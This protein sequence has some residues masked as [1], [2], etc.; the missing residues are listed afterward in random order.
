MG[1]SLAY[2]MFTFFTQEGNLGNYTTEELENFRRQWQDEIVAS[3]G[4]SIT[5]LTLILLFL[6]VLLFVGQGQHSQVPNRHQLDTGAKDANPNNDDKVLFTL[7]ANKKVISIKNFDLQAM[8][9]YLNG[10]KHE[11]SGELLE[12]IKC[13]KRAIHLSPDI[14][15]R[16]YTK[17]YEAKGIAFLVP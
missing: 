6:I 4:K 15:Q 13:Y 3:Q 2:T 1:I 14:E 8:S 12:A 11:E 16:I 17:P 9:M 10:V 5:F 7:S